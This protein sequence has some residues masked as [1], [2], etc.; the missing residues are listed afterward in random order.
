MKRYT[1]F[2]FLIAG[3]P[4][5]LL[6]QGKVT[7]NLEKRPITEVLRK[8]EQQ[9]GYTFSYNPTLLKDFPPVSLRIANESL[10]KV[11]QL[12]FHE[13]DIQPILQ[14]KYIILKK[15]PKAITVSG[16]IYD[17]ESHES[18]IAA[19]V[20]DGDSGQG[21]VSNNFG[22]YSLSVPP[23][24]IELRPSYVGY[25]TENYPFT[26]TKD[27]VIHFFL[28]PSSLL[29]EVV[30][31][32]NLK[33][34]LQ[35]AETGKISLNAATLKGIPAFMGESDVI[36][37][38][39]QM[40]GVA[41]GTDGMAGL[42]VRGGNADEN[43]YLVDGNP[44]Y[45]VHHLLGLFSTFNPEAVK[46]M[47]FYKGS[48][49]A[50][51]GGRLS[52]VVDVRMNDGDMKKFSG[53]ASLGIISSRLNLQ[54]PIIKDRT[55][56][57]V[58]FRRTYLDLIA[59]PAMYFINRKEKRKSPDNYDKIDFSYYFYDFNAK[60]NHKFSD[61]SRIY[62]SLY[63][64]KDKLFVNNNSI[65]RYS[66]DYPTYGSNP[67][68]PEENIQYHYKSAFNETSD[69]DIGWGNRMSSL[70]WTYAVNSKLF[71]NTTLVYNRY[72]S[73]ISYS[74]EIK[75]TYSSKDY[76]DRQEKTQNTYQ[77]FNPIYRSGIEDLGYRLDFDYA[78][79]NSHL[80]RFGTALLQHN[81]V[82]EES[83]IF[84]QDNDNEKRQ[85]DTITYADERVRVQELSLYA[86][87]EVDFGKR[88]KVNAGVH[89]SGFFVQGK[90]YLSLQP[91][92]ST[93]YLLSE[94]LSLKA[95]YGRMSQYVHL[96]QNSYI[97]SPNDLWVP[98]T[99][100]VKPLSSDQFTVGIYGRYRDFDL[101]AETYYKRSVNQVEYKDGANI[102]TSNTN[103]E[104][105]VAQGI[106]TSYGLELMAKRS[107]ENT[108]GWVGYTLSWANRQFP[109]GEINQGKVYPAKYD[110]RHKINA[111]LKHTFNHK[112]DMHISWIYATGNWTTLPMEEYID[113]D[114][115]KI[116]Y[117]HQRNNYKMPDYHRLDLDFN[118]YRHKKNGR[119]GIWNINIYNLYA[120]HNSFIIEPMEGSS[121]APGSVN[122]HP[123]K[124]Y[125][126]YQ[127][128]SL[129]PI[130]PS[131]SYTYKF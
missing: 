91:R 55:S 13:T 90:T 70:N 15:R 111:V 122:G 16:F 1:I 85:N 113:M 4:L 27:T 98:I 82:P 114:G 50:R 117:F 51:Y 105:R 10:E 126:A 40:P 93:R 9:T 94:N 104:N 24:E 100:K 128:Y 116:P 57:S 87:D 103:W 124:Y 5:P 14:E 59:R 74:Y 35:H 61:K 78:Y 101:S 75:E 80:I 92:L 52:S 69:T 21:S 48:F 99:K 43:L 45:H 88:L 96:L 63:N 108:S 77:L 42:Y 89:F 17:R 38:L 65:T 67:D 115:N 41:V 97:N 60:V 39:Q 81:F 83:R 62:L 8:I 22:F 107:F 120:H 109:H 26:V 64:G 30:V 84:R 11:L 31:D 33:N 86:E 129:F 37:A 47:D 112:F 125:P 53:T 95:S 34:P 131:F 127:S 71:S 28:Q 130:I 2:L 102:L 76:G 6:P 29:K 121:P 72:R 12:L 68:N 46:T 119:M 23:G 73:D 36:K 118:Y 3:F 56:F 110:N 44:L 66:N 54:G 123:K 18:L 32:G 25:T 19:N 7:L 79:N 58:S 20:Y 49:P 106:G